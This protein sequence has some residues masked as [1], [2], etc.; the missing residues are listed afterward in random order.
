[1][2]KCSVLPDHDA[3]VINS[4]L[5]DALARIARQGDPGI[6]PIT[7]EGLIA[8]ARDALDRIE[9]LTERGRAR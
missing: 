1:M 7:R 6:M 9:L 8:I 2:S 3:A 4:R 5:F